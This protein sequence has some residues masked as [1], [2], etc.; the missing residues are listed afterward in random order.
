MLPGGS[1]QAKLYPRH[2]SDTQEYLTFFVCVCVCVQL[3]PYSVRKQQPLA[4]L[5]YIQYNL[6]QMSCLSF[7]IIIQKNTMPYIHGG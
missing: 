1:I 2:H 7:K 6:M 5:E 3:S 4:T